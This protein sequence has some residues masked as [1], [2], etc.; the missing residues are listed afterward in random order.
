MSSNKLN[1][2]LYILL[3]YLGILSSH[4]YHLSLLVLTLLLAKAKIST[5]YYVRTQGMYI[6]SSFLFVRFLIFIMN[7]SMIQ[8][9]RA[10]YLKCL[11]ELTLIFHL[12]KYTHIYIYELYLQYFQHVIIIFDWFQCRVVVKYALEIL[13]LSYTYMYTYLYKYCYNFYL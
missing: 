7:F 4:I 3:F 5:A 2:F 13:L 8:K 6:F 10:Y 9:R 11:L 12:N 1:F